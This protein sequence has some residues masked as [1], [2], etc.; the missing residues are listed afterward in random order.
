MAIGAE[1]TKHNNRL[2]NGGSRSLSYI[3]QVSGY[4]TPDVFLWD[5]QADE[6][7]KQHAAFTELYVPVVAPAQEVPLVRSLNVSAALRYDEYS[8]FGSTVNP[9]LGF[10]WD[11]TD[12]FAVR[13]SWGTSFRAPGLPESNNGVF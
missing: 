12:E 13:A 1:Y 4:G 5:A 10:T 6:S 9:K 8:D 3:G 7:R 11:L 2:Q